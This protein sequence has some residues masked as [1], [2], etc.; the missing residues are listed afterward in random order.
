MKKHYIKKAVSYSVAGSLGITIVGALQGCGET[1]LPPAEG[2]QSQTSISDA[3]AEGFFMIIQQTGTNPD[4]YELKEKYPSSEGTRAILRTMDGNERVLSQEELTALAD[5]EAK[6][7]EAGES[8]L[9]QPASAESQG[10]GLGSMILASAA[11]ALLG[12]A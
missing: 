5:A 4:L 1:G 10:M 3:A 2:Q 11:G 6:K 9:N 7:M 8:E 12:N